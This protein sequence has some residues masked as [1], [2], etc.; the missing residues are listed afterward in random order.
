MSDPFRIDGPALVQFSGGRTSAYMLWRILQAHGGALPDDVKVAFE[1]TGKEMPET[2]NFVRDCGERWDVPIVWLEYRPGG[3]AEVD[4]ETAARSGEPFD[5]MLASKKMLPNPVMRF[6]TIEL[7]IR[8]G[9]RYARTLGWTDYTSVTGLRADE[10]GR[11]ARARARAATR[12]DGFDSITPLATAGTTKRDV[13]AFWASQNWGLALPSVNGTTPLGNCDLCFLKS[14]ATLSGIM[15]ERPALADWW[16]SKEAD[17][18]PTN[19]ASAYFRK[20]RPSYAAL[21]DAV[22]R[23]SSMDFGEADTLTDCYC[24]GDA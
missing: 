9:H 11:V 5:A 24:T 16:I 15:R 13:A 3:F 1:N 19:A 4:F 7:K 20:D 2:L 10:M 12:K 6:C 22:Q 21:L 23:Q 17:A 14:A 8:V 18:N